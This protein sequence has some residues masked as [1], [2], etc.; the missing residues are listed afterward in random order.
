MVLA[1][2]CEESGSSA[3][4]LGDHGHA[5]Q[6]FIEGASFPKLKSNRAIPAERTGAG[7]DQISQA[8]EPA[9]GFRPGAKLDGKAGHLSQSPGDQRRECVGPETK[10]LAGSRGNGHHV[11]H[12]AGKF[13]AEHV[14]VGVQ[15]EGRACE[16]F[17]EE[18]RKRV[19]KRGENHGSRLAARG[20]E[21][22]RRAGKNRKAWNEADRADLR[23]D[24]AGAQMRGRLQALGGTH[25]DGFGR[26]LR[27][28]SRENLACMCGRNHADDYMGAVE[29]FTKVAR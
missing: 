18:S 1:T 22:K 29:S 27:K 16:F 25:D 23:K 8:C 3:N 9:K 26:Y 10:S 7:E 4:A 24:F 20:F 17:L 28:R 11:F 6:D 13:H 19:I 21:G 2:E 14:V 5:L 15:P 12:G